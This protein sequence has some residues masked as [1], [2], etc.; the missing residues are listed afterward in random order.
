[1]QRRRQA[2]LGSTTAWSACFFVAGCLFHHAGESDSSINRG[3][4]QAATN[5]TR[6]EPPEMDVP[7]PEPHLLSNYHLLPVARSA[8]LDPPLEAIHLDIRPRLDGS[9]TPQSESNVRTV[10]A[11]TPPADPPK[12]DSPLVAALRCALEKHPRK[13][14]ALLQRY[15]VRDRELLL[16]LL[17]LTAGLGE[18]ELAK[19]PPEEVERTLDQLQGLTQH[20]RKRAP[21][22]LGTVCFC[23]RIENFGQFIPM[24]VHFQFQAGEDGHA[25]ERVQVYAEVRNF[26]SILRKGQY[27][28]RL[29]TSLSILDEKGREM[30]SRN[31]EP[32]PCIDRS[33]TPRQDYFLNLQFHVFPRLPPGLYTLWVTV[34][35]GTP[36]G[37]GQPNGPRVARRSLD[38]RVCPSG[39]RTAM[40]P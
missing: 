17:S 23:E 4:L 33:H 29:Y 34:K 10:S 18:G 2:W 22:S 5:D 40:Q 3:E 9:S 25:G 32:W 39:M 13:A 26:N 28:T 37:P 38:F 30:V 1:M 24:P 11:N 14:Q 7:P 20:L 36:N 21:M 15:D 12:Q 27:E 8:S 6:A 35:D 31:L 16:A 19:L